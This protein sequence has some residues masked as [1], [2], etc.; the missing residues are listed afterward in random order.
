MNTMCSRCETLSDA[1]RRADVP[2]HLQRVGPPSDRPRF[3]RYLCLA[4]GSTWTWSFDAGWGVI[5]LKRRASPPAVRGAPRH[6]QAPMA[7]PG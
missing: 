3:F 2:S 1:P 6:G 7:H 4:C 5:D